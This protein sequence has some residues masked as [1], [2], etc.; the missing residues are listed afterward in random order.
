MNDVIGLSQLLDYDFSQICDELLVIWVLKE[1]K[2]LG[3]WKFAGA[4]VNIMQ[5]VFGMPDSR[6]IVPPNAKFGKFL[7]ND[8]KD[9]RTNTI[10]KHYF[11]D[12]MNDMLD[13]Y[14]L[15]LPYIKI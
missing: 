2:Y 14:Y 4:F 6:P 10:G 12:V 5:E 3:L 1:L 13:D 11:N 9:G 8:I 7:L 15:M